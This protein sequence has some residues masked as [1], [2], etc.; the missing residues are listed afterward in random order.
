MVSFSVFFSEEGLDLV[1][2]RQG[3]RNLTT[4]WRLNGPPVGGQEAKSGFK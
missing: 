4:N 3:N 2:D 1:I